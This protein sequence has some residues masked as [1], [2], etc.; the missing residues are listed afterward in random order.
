ME[1]KE[2]IK[3]TSLESMIESTLGAIG[4]P[5]RDSYEYEVSILLIGAKIRDKWEAQGFSIEDISQKSGLRIKRLKKI[6]K[7]P[8]DI[9]LSELINL[10]KV[11]NIE[12]IINAKGINIS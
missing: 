3:G 6:I 5:E 9:R 1:L 2:K 11:L 7:N 10:S 8:E 4:T 12:I